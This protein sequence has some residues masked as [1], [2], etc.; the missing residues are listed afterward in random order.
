M[1][2][3][4]QAKI[5]RVKGRLP[6]NK[7]KR[8]RANIRHNG[9][10]L[11]MFS[12]S[13]GR[14]EGYLSSPHRLTTQKSFRPAGQLLPSGQFFSTR[15]QATHWQATPTGQLWPTPSSFQETP[16]LTG[17]NRYFFENDNTKCCIQTQSNWNSHTWLVQ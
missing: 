7:N 16:L 3:F 5:V 1:A 4:Q 15:W 8:A 12:L 6:K 11:K 2:S 10:I 14:S 9:K 13:L 17:Q